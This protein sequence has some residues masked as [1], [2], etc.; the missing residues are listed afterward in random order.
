[1]I[2]LTNFYEIFITNIVIQPPWRKV[3]S[4]AFDIRYSI[5]DIRY[6]ILNKIRSYY[7]CKVAIRSASATAA[8]PIAENPCSNDEPN[9]RDKIGINK[10]CSSK[11][12]W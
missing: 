8:D 9:N 1:M 2:T 5:F 6:S 11:R 12:D 7:V 10:P 4:E 3:N